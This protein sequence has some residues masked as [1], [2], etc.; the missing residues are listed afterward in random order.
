MRQSSNPW[1]INK[2]QAKT[3]VRKKS[4]SLRVVDEW[5]RLPDEAKSTDYGCSKNK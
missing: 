2:K 3:E 1:N 4:F 5:N